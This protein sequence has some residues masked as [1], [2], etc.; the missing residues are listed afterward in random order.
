MDPVSGFTSVSVGV[1]PSSVLGGT[2]A[3]GGDFQS[4]AE[5]W[6]QLNE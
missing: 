1:G 4:V 2:I 5:L 6:K 3:G